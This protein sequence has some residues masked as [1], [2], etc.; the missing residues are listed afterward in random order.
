VAPA[1]PVT[2]QV[3]GAN[4]RYFAFG[5]V[6]D[7]VQRLLDAYNFLRPGWRADGGL[8]VADSPRTAQVGT[9]P[10][11]PRRPVRLLSCCLPS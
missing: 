10:H 4:E 6:A 5:F 9:S 8:C 11:D 1:P 7:P 2:Q 3:G